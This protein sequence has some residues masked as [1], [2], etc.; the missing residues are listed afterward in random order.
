[1]RCAA[2]RMVV[3]G[4]QTVA[5][6]RMRDETGTL[7]VSLA[8]GSMRAVFSRRSRSVRATKATPCGRLR[9][10][11]AISRGIAYRRQ[12][13]LARTEISGARPVTSVGWP[14]TPPLVTM[15]T[16]CPRAMSSR[17]P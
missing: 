17:V 1:M 12:S 5:G 3:S 2:S 9:M 8:G 7:R 16:T 6:R 10:P 13:S 4:V 14:T 15:S 11:I